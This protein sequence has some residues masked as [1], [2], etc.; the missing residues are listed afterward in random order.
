MTDYQLTMY[1]KATINLIVI[2]LAVNLAACTG[3]VQGVP[4]YAV[5]QPG[6]LQPIRYTTL[7]W[8]LKD[9][10]I[11]G[12]TRSL[13]LFNESNGMAM[14]SFPHAGG[15]GWI[16]LDTRM[17]SLANA[18][19]KAGTLGQLANCS[20]FGCI[21]KAAESIGY[22]QI[23]A[24]DLTRLAP[25]FVKAVATATGNFAGTALPSIF[26]IPAGVVGGSPWDGV[27]Q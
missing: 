22:R 18:L 16:V 26:V 20:D 17:H 3:A 9:A 14:V 1:R 6:Q 19:H 15:W 2:L 4:S 24:N 13:I 23:T 12:S 5:P 11:M 10:V 27:Q 7:L 8:Q 21:V 25:G